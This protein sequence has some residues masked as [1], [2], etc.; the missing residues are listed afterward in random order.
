MPSTLRRGL[1]GE[2]ETPPQIATSHC[3]SRMACTARTTATRDE[4]HAV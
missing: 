1:L 3:P 2:S 4:E